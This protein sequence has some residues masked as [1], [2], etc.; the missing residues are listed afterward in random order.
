VKPQVIA[1]SKL[2]SILWL[3]VGLACAM[4][5]VVLKIS[6]P[7]LFTRDDKS[8]GDVLMVFGIV[9]LISFFGLL[10]FGALLKKLLTSGGALVLDETGLRS[11]VS[12]L[13]SKHIEWS[14]VGRAE[15]HS[16]HMRHGMSY[17]YVAILSDEELEKR[18]ENF[19]MKRLLMGQKLVLRINALVLDRKAADVANVIN[20]FAEHYN[21]ADESEQHSLSNYVNK[22]A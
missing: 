20:E 19:S 8:S 21:N 13:G 22:A 7:D 16:Q 18:A 15:V 12:G 3:S 11:A 14:E 2:K 5:P 10:I 4:T 9:G 6:A 17:N 1:F